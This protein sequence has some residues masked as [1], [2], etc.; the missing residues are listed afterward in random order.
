MA[1]AMQDGRELGEWRA[2]AL[3]RGLAECHGREQR[4][5]KHIAPTKEF[6]RE[7][8]EPVLCFRRHRVYRV[9]VALIVRHGGKFQP[10]LRGGRRYGSMR[11]KGDVALGQC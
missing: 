4:G 1:G 8:L 3:E 6:L 10:R 7:S 5:P 9:S 11:K 2:G